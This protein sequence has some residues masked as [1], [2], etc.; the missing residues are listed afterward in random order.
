MNFLDQAVTDYLRRMVDRY[1]DP[2]LNEMEKL[3]EERGFPIVGRT[4]GAALEV[5]ARS[6]GAQRVME[7]GSGY[8]Y[9]GLWFARAVG[10]KGK[11]ILTDGDAENAKQAE[12]FLTR[13]GV[14]DRCEFMVGDA[15]TSLSSTK[16]EFDVVYCDIDKGGYPEAFA[17]ARTR[18]RVGGL[19]LADNV[20]WSG[21]VASDDDDELTQAIRRHNE[22]IYNDKDYRPFILPIRDGVIVALRVS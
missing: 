21:R 6:I 9:S 11:V 5:L 22:D 19:Y 17:A 14:W 13:A 16:G 10:S 4:V 2:V 3:A 7:L 15:V 8:G 1:D 20:L 18:I 12:D